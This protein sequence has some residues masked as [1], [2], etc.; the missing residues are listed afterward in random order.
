MAEDLS[1][2][3]Q[4][5]PAL[6]QEDPFLGRFLLAFERVLSGLPSADP[7]NFPSVPLGLEQVLDRIHTYFDPAGPGGGSTDYAPD[8]FLPWLAGWVATSLREDWDTDTRRRFIANIV[9]LYRRRG[10]KTALQQ[11]LQLYTGGAVEVLEDPKPGEAPFPLRYFQVRFTVTERDPS[12]L[13]RKA[14]I[15]IALI[16]REKPAHTFYGLKISFP[17]LQIADPPTYD[18]A[19]NPQS[20]VF[21]GVNTTLGGAV[22]TTVTT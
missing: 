5:L 11:L 3:M 9:P 6:F 19:G 8:D 20:G 14:A 13:S 7:P 22:V 17:S 12:L 10:T 1:R 2:Y 21:V 15:A 4:H 18:A 16:D